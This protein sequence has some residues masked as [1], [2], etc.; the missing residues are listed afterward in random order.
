MQDSSNTG[1]AIPC[2]CAPAV[3]HIVAF[4]STC[5]LVLCLHGSGLSI[6]FS[7]GSTRHAFSDTHVIIYS[8]T[9]LCL[10]KANIQSHLETYFSFLVMDSTVFQTRTGTAEWKRS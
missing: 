3:L 2:Y 4:I 8:S 9:Q 1:S 10:E 5:Y 6:M 7:L